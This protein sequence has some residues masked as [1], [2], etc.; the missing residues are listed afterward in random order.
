[1]WLLCTVRIVNWPLLSMEMKNRNC[2]CTCTKK[3]SPTLSLQLTLMSTLFYFKWAQPNRTGC[4]HFIHWK[5]ILWF[6]QILALS[7]SSIGTK[8]VSAVRY[9]RWRWA[10]RPTKALRRNRTAVCECLHHTDHPDGLQWLNSSDAPPLRLNYFVGVQFNFITST[11]S[12]SWYFLEMF[13]GFITNKTCQYIYF[14]KLLCLHEVT[15]KGSVNWQIE[16]CDP[17]NP[18][19]QP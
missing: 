2:S 9:V 19:P 15:E 16:S 7:L 11:G 18:L 10:W 13:G 5:F 3:N 12:K 14:W 8:V 4:F 17:N 1:M 6:P